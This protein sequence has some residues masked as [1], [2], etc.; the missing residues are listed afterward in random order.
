M[1]GVDD[2]SSERKYGIFL[3]GAATHIITIY[4]C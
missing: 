1:A 4:E 2:L 3:D